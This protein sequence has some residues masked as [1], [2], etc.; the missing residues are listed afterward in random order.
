MDAVALVA[1]LA[2]PSTRVLGDIRQLCRDVTWLQV[3]ADL[4][5]EISTNWLRSN[6]PGKLLYTLPSRHGKVNFRIT[7][8]ERFDRMRTAAQ[9]YDLVEL[10]ADSDLT[11]AMLAAIPVERRLISWRGPACNACDLHATFTR[12]AAVPAHSYCLVTTARKASDGLQP[13]LFL[14]A[15]GRK[16]VT[17]FCEGAAGFWS[18]LLAPNFGSPFLFGRL[19]LQADQAAGP[20]IQQLREDYGF[21]V[22]RPIQELYGIVGNPV[23]KSLSPRLHNA[24]YRILNYPA[25]FVPF[26]VESFE[27]FWRDM[28][29]TPTLKSIGLPIKGLTVVSPHKEDALL[30][31]RRRSPMVRLTGATNICVLRSGV[32][33]AHTTDQESVAGVSRVGRTR[34]GRLRAAVVGCGGAGRAVAAALKQAGAEVILVNR[35]KERGDRAVKLLGLPFVLL[36]KF[37]LSGFTLLVNATPVGRDGDSLPFEIDTLGRAPLVVDLVYGVRPTPLVASVLAQGGAVIDGYEVLLNQVRKQ[38][39]I[40]TGREMPAAIGRQIVISCALGNFVRAETEWQNRNSPRSRARESRP[41]PIE[42]MLPNEGRRGGM[43][44]ISTQ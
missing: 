13:L 8:R 20:H 11:E 30:V 27:G 1:A 18:R 10:D 6:F 31:A 42:M 29:E 35:G 16:D 36:S 22:L 15:L 32:W 28:V 25:L 39:R 37:K 38:F 21:P 40:M 2:T 33:E 12:L 43:K 41:K 19:D 17:A 9:E 44:G 3:R 7:D 34:R 26:H 14:K 5:G 23:L 4:T 24:G